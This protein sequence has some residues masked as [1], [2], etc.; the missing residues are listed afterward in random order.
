MTKTQVE[1]MGGKIWVESV[2]DQGT[3]FFIEFDNRIRSAS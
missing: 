2:P 1:A 3:A